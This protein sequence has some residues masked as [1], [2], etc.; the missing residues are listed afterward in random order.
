[1]KKLLEVKNLKKEYPIYQGIL[2]RQTG[3]VKAVDGV[4]FDV[5]HNQIVGIVGE[6]GSGKTTLGRCVVGLIKP[7]SGELLLDRPVQM[8]FQDPGGA[9]NPRH[10]LGDALREPLL[11]HG[12]AKSR[13]EADFAVIEVLYKIGFDASILN[14]F[15][16]Q[17]SLGQKQRLAIARSILLKPELIVCD[18]P[19]SALDV[20]VQSQ[21]LNL[22]LDLKD[23]LKM[24]LLFITH[25]LAVVR[26]IASKILVMQGGK[27]VEQGTREE[28]FENP[29]H[30]Y[31]KRL[32]E[33]CPA[34][35]IKI[36]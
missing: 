1:M 9:L 4:T 11:Y 13:A 6:S 15:P 12:I 19:V 3:V 30:P 23:S 21:I 28:I 18:E 8:I 5:D 24:S 7:T 35:R 2:R 25:D 22:F 16:H 33:S 10:T 32:L 34:R 14:R 27:I 26:F 20:S 29:Q 36:E 17:F 31:T